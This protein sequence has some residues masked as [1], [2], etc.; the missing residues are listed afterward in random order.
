MAQKMGVDGAVDDGIGQA[1]D[2][3]VFE[4]LPDL[5]GVEFVVFHGEILG[6]LAERLVRRLSS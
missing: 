1:R 6:V 5:N 2:E 3:E 4:L